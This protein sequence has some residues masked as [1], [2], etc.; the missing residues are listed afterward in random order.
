M[1]FVQQSSNTDEYPVDLWLASTLNHCERIHGQS[2]RP[3]GKNGLEKD[4]GFLNGKRTAFIRRFP[5]KLKAL[6]NFCLTLSHACTYSHS[7]GGVDHVGGQPARQ[8]RLGVSEL[9][10]RTLILS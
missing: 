9:L 3:S 4:S 6:Y 8:E 10:R 5:G 2:Y 7:D 1:T